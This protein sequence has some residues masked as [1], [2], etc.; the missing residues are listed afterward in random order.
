MIAILLL[1][2]LAVHNG[3]YWRLLTPGEYRVTATSERYEPQ[4]HLVRVVSRPRQEA[5]KVNFRLR[6]LSNDVE[7]AQRQATAQA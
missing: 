1:V 7:L 3:D 6:P 4:T 5:Q 2:F